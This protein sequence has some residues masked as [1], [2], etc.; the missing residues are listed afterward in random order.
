MKALIVDDDRTLADVLAFTL[1]REGFQVILAYDGQMAL[2]RWEEESP[3]IIILDV[4]L[5]RLDG[6]TVCQQIRQQADT[7]ILLLTVRGEEE[8]IVRG[9]RLG[10][11]DYI[12][13]PFSPRQ[14][15][16]RMQA[17]LRR[18]GQIPTLALRRL[19]DLTLDLG[20]REL[21]VG[22][23][24]PVTLTALEARLLDF[25]TNNPGQVMTTESII[26]YVWGPR[27]ADRDMVRQLVHRL[28]LK[29]E[30]DPNNPEYIETVAGLGYGFLKSNEIN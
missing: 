28:R 29:I 18:I 26:D 17:I 6:F 22:N 21:V 20:R 9:L 8:D 24:A 12:T 3:D 25:L 23:Q 4:N 5:P 15:V 16:A 2:Q 27:G 30:P 11:D 19:G 1:R 10:A 13:K 7:P 14:L